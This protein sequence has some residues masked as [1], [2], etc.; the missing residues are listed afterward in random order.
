MASETTRRS[1]EPRKF[2]PIAALF[3]KLGNISSHCDCVVGREGT[4]LQPDRY[5]QEPPDPDDLV[6]TKYLRAR[7]R[8]FIH[9]RRVYFIGESLPMPGASLVPA[10][11][12]KGS[13]V[14]TWTGPACTY[15]HMLANCAAIRSRIIGE[16]F[17][18]LPPQIDL[19]ISPKAHA[20]HEPFSLE[21]R[22]SLHRISPPVL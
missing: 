5:G 11:P 12:T 6:I 18:V 4:H 20:R 21:M 22:S 1:F 8:T 15:R 2:P 10:G 19:M 3:E 13:Q 14:A 17:D 7:A 16:M 9:V